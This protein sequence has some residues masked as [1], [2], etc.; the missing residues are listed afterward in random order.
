MRAFSASAAA[1]FNSYKFDRPLGGGSCS[2]GV[3][4]GPQHRRQ[5]KARVAVI[6][7][8]VRALSN[9]DSFLGDPSGAVVAPPRARSCARTDRQAIAAFKSF[10]ARRSLS[11]HNSS[12]SGS[13]SS[14][15]H[16][17]ANNAAVSAVSASRPMRRKP[18]YAR[19]R[20]RLCGRG[21]VS[22]QL[23][24]PCELVDLE[25]GVPHTEFGE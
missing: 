17:R 21:I 13:L 19:R 10:P 24:D 23:D 16:A 2:R 9:G 5:R 22:D 7:Q 20:M 18:L 15:R 11:V 25:Q 14:A 8:Q 3:T 6:D 1:P 12:A 4:R